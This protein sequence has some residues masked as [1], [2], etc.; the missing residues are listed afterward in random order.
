MSILQEFKDY[1]AHR[2]EVRK[3]LSED[4]PNFW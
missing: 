1:R 4:N 3:T 2:Q